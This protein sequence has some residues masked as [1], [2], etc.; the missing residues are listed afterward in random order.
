MI[1]IN[2]MASVSQTA[3][4]VGRSATRAVSRQSED[5]P[6]PQSVGAS[7]SASNA[8][9]F[10][11]RVVRWMT[12][13]R[14]GAVRCE[15]NCHGAH[16]YSTGCGVADVDEIDAG[17]LQE[18]GR[19][20]GPLDANRT[21]RVDLHAY[22]ELPAGQLPGKFRWGSGVV[23]AADFGARQA[24][25]GGCGRVRFAGCRSTRRRVCVVLRLAAVV[26]TAPRS[27]VMAS[28]RPAWRGYGRGGPAAA[29]DNPRPAASICGTISPKYSGPAE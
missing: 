12:H 20:E 4:A 22:D 3:V 5:V 6:D 21:R 14:S 2:P 8:I 25:R 26:G 23:A 16:T 13:S 28:M 24:W 7:N 15:G 29:A 19:L 11:S 17:G 27:S 18:S 10:L 1:S 9:M